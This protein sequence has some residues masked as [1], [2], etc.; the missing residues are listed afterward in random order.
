M[1]ERRPHWAPVDPRGIALPLALMVLTLLSSLALAF[2]GFSATEPTIAANFKRGEEALA[3]AE[4]G[5]ER[6]IWALSNPASEGLTNLNQIPPAYKGQTLFP[7]GAAAF[8]VTLTGAE[9]IL[10]TA[11][12]Y[13]VRN[14]VAVPAQPTQLALA[15]IAAMRT[16]QLQAASTGPLGGPGID[17]NLPGALTVAGSIQTSGNTT[18]DGENQAPGVRNDCPKKAG[19]TIRTTTTLPDGTVVSNTANSSGS[20]GLTGNPGSQ[21]LPPNQ[22]NPSLFTQSQLD[23]LKALAQA[24]GTY[25]KP[26]N[27]A[28]FNLPVTNGLTFVDTVNGEPLG[29]P[30]DASMLASV[31]ITSANNS[32]WLIV[33]GTLRIDGNVTYNG[34]VYAHNDLS[35]KGTGAGGV[36]GAV[37]S[38]NVVDDVAT[39]FDTDVGGATRIYYD[40]AK[41]ANGGGTFSASLNDSLKRAMVTVTPG[42]W[43]EVSN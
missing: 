22:F 19:V 9:P 37:V 31:K 3:L 35:Y 33:M 17:Q 38:A 25:I 26:S 7:L 24:Q 42:S 27:N 4:A 5:V 34:L 2:L 21:A 43:R 11:R 1:G 20:S 6:A 18:V 8:S 29:S 15:D 28:Q 32:G 12:G 36:Y 14:G 13:V 16:V 40:C 10:I 41:V 23:G 30:P 39:V